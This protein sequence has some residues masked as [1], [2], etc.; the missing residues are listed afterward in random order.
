MTLLSDIL[1]SAAGGEGIKG[2]IQFSGAGVIAIAD[3]FNVTSI[4]DNGVG[5]YT[6]TWDTDFAN[7]NYSV[8][9]GVNVYHVA[10][11]ALP[12]AQATRVNT[13]SNAHA[14]QDASVVC[15]HAIG[16]Q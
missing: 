16:D 11:A 12:T 8:T 7:A 14:V 13:F 1:S 15:L 10:F 9:F 5:D 6:V 2:W 4:T 3:S